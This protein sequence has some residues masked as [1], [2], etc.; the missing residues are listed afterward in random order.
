MPNFSNKLPPEGRHQ[1]YDLK[2]TPPTGSIAA[3]VTCDDMIVC[4]THF[5]GGRTIPCERIV[6]NEGKTSDE[7]PCPACI[8]KQGWRTH[9]YLSAFNAK[10]REHFIFEC[11]A[12]AAKAF[13][14]YRDANPT[15]RGCA[16]NA[17]RPKGTPNGKVVIVTNS[18]NMAKVNAPKAP[19]VPRA[20]AVIW[21]LPA[22]AINT[23]PDKLAGLDDPDGYA[24]RD[25]NIHIDPTSTAKMHEQLDDAGALFDIEQRRADI[26]AALTATPSGN[27]QTK[28]AKEKA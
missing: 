22:T 2:R 7:S 19:D 17:S 10:T 5:Y 12:N 4:D 16:F 1:G 23:S 13:E 11:S 6:N 20:L 9:A 21:R 8:A 3:I 25:D 18:V 15:L 26:L 24:R 27:G 14:E 28:K